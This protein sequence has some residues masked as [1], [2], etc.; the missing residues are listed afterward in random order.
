MSFTPIRM[1][2]DGGL[3][4]LVGSAVERE[5]LLAHGYRVVEDA[6]P[7]PSKAAEPKPVAKRAEPDKK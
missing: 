3:A 4:V 1:S 7:A 5:H 6:K 2:K